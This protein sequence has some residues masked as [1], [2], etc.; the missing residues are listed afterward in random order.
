MHEPRAKQWSW[1]TAKRLETKR[2]FFRIRIF[3]LAKMWVETMVLDNSQNARRNE[4]F[5]ESEFF[6]SLKDI[7]KYVGGN[8]GLGQQ[9]KCSTKRIFF[10]IPNFFTRSKRSRNTWVETMVLDNSQ[11]ARRNEFFSDSEFFSSLKEIKK[12]VGGKNGLGQQPKC[13]TKRIFF[14]SRIF[15]KEIKKCVGRTIF[16]RR[17]EHVNRINYNY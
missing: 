13:S 7:K 16:I 3:F 6:P 11:N 1:T 17:S 10:Q 8:N 15:L 12:Y 5:S 2:I 14:R 9:P 4:F